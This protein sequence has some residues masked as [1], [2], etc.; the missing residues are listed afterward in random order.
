M[1]GLSMSFLVKQVDNDKLVVPKM[2]E[3]FGTPSMARPVSTGF[4][5][6]DGIDSKF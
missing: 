4:F 3:T 6:A 5:T 2:S 1:K